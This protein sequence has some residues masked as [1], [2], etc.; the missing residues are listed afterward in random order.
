MISNPNTKRFRSVNKL[1]GRHRWCITATPIG[2]SRRDLTTLLTWVSGAKGNHHGT[3]MDRLAAVEA[4]RNIGASSV[5]SRHLVMLR[6]TKQ[7]QI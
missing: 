2:N 7:V 5:P 4:A 6:R 1:A 3:E